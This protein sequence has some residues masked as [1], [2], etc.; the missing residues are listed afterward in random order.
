MLLSGG[1]DSISIAYWKRPNYAITIDYGQL[2]AESEIRA[3]R[4][5]CNLLDIEHIVLNVDC[6][7]LGSGDLSGKKS[8]NLAPVTEWWPYR[9]QLLITLASMK[10]LEFNVKTLLIGSVSNDEIHKDGTK[11]FYDKISDL[12]GM[13]EGELK[14]EVPAIGFTTVELI[15]LSSIP[16]SKLL[17]AHSCHKSNEP[18]MNCN[19]CN[20]Y[21]FTLQYL[22]IE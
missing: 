7:E 16:L 13:Q 12:I 9:N 19:G 8:I 22:G 15:K 21:L 5:I 11:E 20:K 10:M 17:I 1:M 6:S 14:L 3:A 2:P 18:C 4:S